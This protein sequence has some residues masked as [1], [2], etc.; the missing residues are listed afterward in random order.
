MADDSEYI[1]D[2]CRA[3]Y[4]HTNWGYLDTYTKEDLK[5]AKHDIEKNI[6]YW[7]EENRSDYYDDCSTIVD[8][9]LTYESYLQLA[10]KRRAEAL[11]QW[12]EAL[13]SK[14]EELIEE[15]INLYNKERGD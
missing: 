2:Y 9:E 15:L 6:V 3:K 14:P 4:G 1:D 13:L 8:P 10:E 5:S 11:E 7:H 12:N